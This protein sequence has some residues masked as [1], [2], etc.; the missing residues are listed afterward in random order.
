[1]V[2]ALTLMTLFRADIT[3]IIRSRIRPGVCLIRGP[4]RGGLAGFRRL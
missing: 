3:T 4:F 1:M 2:A